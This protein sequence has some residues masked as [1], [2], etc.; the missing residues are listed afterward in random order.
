MPGQHT[1][2]RF[3]EAI[4]EHLLK[5]GYHRADRD[6]FDAERGF[7]PKAVLSFIKRTQSKEWQYL[8]HLQKTK[9]E[10]VLLDDLCRALDSEHEGCL[11]VLRHGF[12]CF[13][14]SFRV[15]YFA[16]ASGMNPET[17]MLYDENRLSVTRQLRY[18]NKHQS[19]I[20]LVITLNGI[21]VLTAELKNPMTGQTGVTPS[22]NIK[23]TETLT[24]SSSASKSDHWC[25]SPLTPMRHT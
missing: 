22:A 18:S 16:P 11:T 3:E 8:E 10:T 9:T 20:D 7:D 15:A 12:K 5:S 24:I 1:E 14:K 25:I 17:K 21:P 13:G 19:E 23:T 4:E 2:I 6:D